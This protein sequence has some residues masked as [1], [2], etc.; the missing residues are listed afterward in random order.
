MDLCQPLSI[1]M[2]I[3]YGGFLANDLQQFVTSNL[4]F[5]EGS[6]V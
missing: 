1:L 6:E 4:S 3:D 5:T 2:I